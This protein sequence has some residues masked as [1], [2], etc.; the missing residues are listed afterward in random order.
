MPQYVEGFVLP[1]AAI[2]AVCGAIASWQ[3][4][5]MTGGIIVGSCGTITGIMLGVVAFGGDPLLITVS[6]LCGLIYG[7]IAGLIIGKAFPKPAAQPQ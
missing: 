5:T 3:G 4:G 2:W 6:M 7:G 1:V